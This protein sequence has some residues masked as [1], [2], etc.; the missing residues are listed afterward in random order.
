MPSKSLNRNA[1][2]ERTVVQIP[3]TDLLIPF[4]I[5]CQILIRCFERTPVNV[6]GKAQVFLDLALFLKIPIQDCED[7]LVIMLDLAKDIICLVKMKDFLGKV[8]SSSSLGKDNALVLSL[9]EKGW[10]TI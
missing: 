9:E 4:M 3:D 6:E 1:P 7:S 5:S 2:I 8:L 10:S